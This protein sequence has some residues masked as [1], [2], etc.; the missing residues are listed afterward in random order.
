MRAPGMGKG[1]GF[2]LV[3]RETFLL[4][5]SALMTVA[6]A[7]VL[8]GTIYP[9]IIEAFGMG[10]LSVGAPYF[11]A[12]FIPLMVPV[13]I[14]LGFGVLSRWR[15]DEMGRLWQHLKY[16]IAGSII[17]GVL[18]VVM[19]LQSVKFQAILAVTL[20]CWIVWTTLY[21]LYLRLRHQGQPFYALNKVPLNF[22]GMCLAHIGFAITIIGVCITSHY[23]SEIHKRM[24]I[25][26]TVELDGYTFKLETL[27]QHKG[28]NYDAI[29]AEMTVTRNGVPVTSLHSQ[30]RMYPVRGMPM[31]EAGIDA[32]L[33]RDLYVSLGE[34][35]ENTDWS[36][37][38]YHRPYVRWIWLG[39]IF[40]A[41]GGIFAA[42]DRRYRLGVRRTVAD[43]DGNTLKAKI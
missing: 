43:L 29:E 8:L 37:R 21:S 42:T 23:S 14:V 10:K 25:G 9:L 4:I 32:G 31:T 18:L 5:N 1:G 39:A 26:D 36:V 35:L 27:E 24:G 12:V 34:Q 30:K 7:T 3:S 38:I 41:L 17:L 40:M 6:M 19:L 20:A 13:T 28:P 33:T 16:A 2:G 22:L 11:N 15:M